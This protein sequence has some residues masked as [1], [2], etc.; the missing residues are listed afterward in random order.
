MP[1]GKD[2]SHRL[3]RPPR[4]EAAITDRAVYLVEVYGVEPTE[5][6]RYA[7]Q[8]AGLNRFDDATRQRLLRRL[9]AKQREIATAPSMVERTLEALDAQLEWFRALFADHYDLKNSPA[10]SVDLEACFNLFAYLYRSGKWRDLLP[11]ALEPEPE[12]FVWPDRCDD[13]K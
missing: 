9:R 1:A 10:H 4:G 6:C 12:R 8:E 2:V 11:L 13:Q 5:A 7:A 3:G